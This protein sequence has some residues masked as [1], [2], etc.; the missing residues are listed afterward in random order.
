MNFLSN[1]KIFMLHNFNKY[2]LYGTLHALHTLIRKL[3]VHQNK[4]KFVLRTKQSNSHK[5]YAKKLKKT[6]FTGPGK[7][8][9]SCIPT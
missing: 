8:V 4:E 7:S 1:L 6:H 9:R 2:D 5:Y 3:H